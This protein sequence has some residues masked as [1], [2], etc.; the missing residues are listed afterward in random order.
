MYS[1]NRLGH[2]GIMANYRCTAACRHCLYACSPSR[3]AGYIDGDTAKEVCANLRRYG[4]RS[5]H[6]GGGEPFLDF[7]GLLVLVKTARAAGISVEYLET[8]AYWAKDEAGAVKKLRGLINAGVDTLCISIDPFHA[9][10]VP[11]ALP[12][13]LARLCENTGMGYFL[14]QAQYVK[15]VSQLDMER[16]HARKE[17]ERALGEDYILRIAQSYGLRLNGRATGIEREYAQNRPAG[18]LVSGVPCTCLLSTD[19]F[20]VDMHGN[21]I[22]P[23]CTG[24]TIPLGVIGKGVEPGAYPVFEA[25]LYG[26][27]AAMYDYTSERGFEPDPAGY[28]SKCALCLSMRAYLAKNAPSNELDVEYYE[29]IGL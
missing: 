17:W 26:G 1:V 23:G 16:V 11:A 15:S 18:E 29:H 20:H 4:C 19:H 9:E 5:V 3:G 7:E 25:L 21:F 22:P 28:P 24:F 14:W 10:Y 2:G 6:I 12:L 27:A 8:N 13:K